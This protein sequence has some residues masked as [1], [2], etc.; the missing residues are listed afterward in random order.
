MENKIQLDFL[1]AKFIISSR[2]LG[3]ILEG[4]FEDLTLQF[5]IAFGFVC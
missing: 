3:I 4:F 1:R 2:W 5:V